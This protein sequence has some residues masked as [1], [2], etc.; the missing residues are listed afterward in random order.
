M[1]A[2]TTNS[3]LTEVSSSTRRP[4]RPPPLPRHFTTSVVTMCWVDSFTSTTRWPR[5]QA[6]F[7]HDGSHIAGDMRLIDR[8]SKSLRGV[9]ST[10]RFEG[11]TG[12][13]LRQDAPNVGLQYDGEALNQVARRG[14]ALGDRHFGALQVIPWTECIFLAVGQVERM[15]QLRDR[16]MFGHGSSALVGYSPAGPARP[17]RLVLLGQ[18]PGEPKVGQDAQGWFGEPL[19]LW[20]FPARGS[21]VCG[22]QRLGC[23]RE[24]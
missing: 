2:T 14:I 24:A 11:R 15:A 3:V 8:S 20:G 9:A 1:S 12:R 4:Q 22:R 5:S 16:S 18:P 21:V 17:H 19:R 23:P 13:A 7:G 6:V 10:S